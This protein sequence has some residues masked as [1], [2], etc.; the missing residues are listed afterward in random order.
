MKIRK[1]VTKAR[2]ADLDA[3]QQAGTLRSVIV[4]MVEQHN[5]KA[6][7]ARLAGYAVADLKLTADTDV[8]I[9]VKSLI[10]GES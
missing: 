5:D 8:E 9:E 4:W 7:A 2:Q 3:V 10:E 1:L 6:R